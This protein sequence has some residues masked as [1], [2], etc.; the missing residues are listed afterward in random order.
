MAA[1]VGA[2]ASTRAGAALRSRILHHALPYIP[3]HSF[4]LR[5][6]LRSLP[7]LPTDHA[8][9]D[10]AVT[11]EVLDVLFGSEISARKELVQ[12][13]EQEGLRDMLGDT[14]AQARQAGPTSKA[15]EIRTIAGLLARRL[16]Y[17]AR[18]GEH[19]VEVCPTSR[20]SGL[21]SSCSPLGADLIRHRHSSLPPGH[22]P[23][24][25]SPGGQSRSSPQSF[26]HY[27]VRQAPHCSWLRGVKAH[28]CSAQYSRRPMIAYLYFG[29]TPSA[30]SPMAGV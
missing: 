3:E 12:A 11:P 13:W 1:S 9:H 5:P 26:P 21:C 6:L 30:P 16:E 19:L 24:S 7:D 20:R 17:S 25:P 8:D 10:N 27:I 29:S 28:Q 23:R 18:F 14:T 4:T 15:G 22:R 2:S